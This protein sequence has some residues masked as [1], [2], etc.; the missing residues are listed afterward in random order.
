MTRYNRAR[1]IAI[2]VTLVLSALWG[3]AIPALADSGSY[4][5]NSGESC[6]WFGSGSLIHVSCSGYRPSGRY[7]NY[8]CDISRFGSMMSWQCRDINGNSWSGSR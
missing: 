5:T 1:A 7:V 8:N 2:V 3:S 6:T 4:T